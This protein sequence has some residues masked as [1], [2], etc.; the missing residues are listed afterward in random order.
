MF[1]LKSIVN[2][3]LIV[4]VI[5]FGLSGCSSNSLTHAQ[6]LKSSLDYPIESKIET[7]ITTKIS[8][9]KFTIDSYENVSINK[10]FSTTDKSIQIKSLYKVN[11]D[12]GIAYYQNQFE[13]EKKL[14]HDTTQANGLLSGY[15][16]NGKSFEKNLNFYTSLSKLDQYQFKSRLLNNAYIFI[17]MNNKIKTN[18]V[19]R[20][21]FGKDTI[22]MQVSGY[23][24][25]KNKKVIVVNII[26]NTINSSNNMSI[27]ITGYHLYDVENML[28]IHGVVYQ[29]GN[30]GDIT[31][32]KEF[33]YERV[34]K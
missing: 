31:I 14:R 26:P 25:Y 9:D 30:I 11:L 32:E 28:P 15:Y 6:F 5:L 24:M 34:L 23:G 13:G 22:S 18:S 8:K 12:N 4:S 27:S 21:K 10:S 16:T 33:E 17:M 19:L 2:K 3:L 20:Y 1:N 7:E 29:Y